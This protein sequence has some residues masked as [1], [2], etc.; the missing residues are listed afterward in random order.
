MEMRNKAYKLLQV[1]VIIENAINKLDQ[2]GI[3][4]K[5]EAYD[6]F[7]IQI[8][9]YDTFDLNGG[10]FT[11]RGKE[12]TIDDYVMFLDYLMDKYNK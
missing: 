3:F 2:A 4:I 11:I 12:L 10:L 5:K 8:R 9:G 1:I 7:N 6:F